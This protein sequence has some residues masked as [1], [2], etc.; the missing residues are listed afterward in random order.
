LPLRELGEPAP[1]LADAL[2]EHD[3]VLQVHLDHEEELVI[4]ALLELS[5]R[6]FEDYRALGIV[7][8]MRRLD[9]VTGPLGARV[10]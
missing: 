2:E 5:P 8:L 10:V 6:E 4:P 7:E 9:A 3:A 1:G